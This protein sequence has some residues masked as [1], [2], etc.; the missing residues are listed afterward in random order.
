MMD[1][2]FRVLNNRIVCF[3]C[4]NGILCSEWFKIE[5]ETP[6]SF[7]AIALWVPV[8]FPGREGSQCCANIGSLECWWNKFMSQDWEQTI[9]L[10]VLGTCFSRILSNL[11]PGFPDPCEYVFRLTTK[12][13]YSITGKLSSK[14]Q[15]LQWIL[16]L[17]GSMF[18]V[19]WPHTGHFLVVISCCQR[20]ITFSSIMFW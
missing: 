8:Y 9:V 3:N 11:I 16:P 5:P 20:L 17:E 2:R 14:S 6:A 12:S 10:T 4:F 15:L 1:F 19:K 18:R 7:N 13:I